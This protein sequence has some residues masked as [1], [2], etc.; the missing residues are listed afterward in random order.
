MQSNPNSISAFPP[1]PGPPWNDPD[2][3]EC[4][5]RGCFKTIALRIFNSSY[6]FSYGAGLYSFF[7]NY[8]TGCIMT[9]N[10]DERRIKMDQSQGI[11]LRGLANIAAQYMVQV[12]GLDLAPYIENESTDIFDSVAIIEY[13]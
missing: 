2:F 6:I 4:F 5:N 3:S 9:N 10:C 12:D 11:Y 13:P 7:E 8:D 1:R